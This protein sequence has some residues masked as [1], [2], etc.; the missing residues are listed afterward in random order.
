SHLSD[1]FCLQNPE[2]PWVDM[3]NFR[4]FAVHEYFSVNWRIVWD[5]AI[6]DI[7]PIEKQIA[8]LLERYK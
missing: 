4:N 1:A 6:G 2:I 5:T 7:P 8:E 3:I